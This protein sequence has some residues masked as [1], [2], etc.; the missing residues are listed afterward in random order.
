MLFLTWGGGYINNFYIHY[1]LIGGQS[2]DCS[3]RG[4][5]RTI[6]TNGYST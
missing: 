2:N 4:G 6:S 3:F 1:L 5:I